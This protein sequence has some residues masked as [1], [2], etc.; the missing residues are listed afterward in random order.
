MSSWVYVPQPEQALS[1]DLSRLHY[2][3]RMILGD[4]LP[5]SWRST[6]FRVEPVGEQPGTTAKEE[7]LVDLHELILPK[8]VLV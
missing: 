7:F 1:I 4:T 8:A 3:I 2:R 5:I 6:I